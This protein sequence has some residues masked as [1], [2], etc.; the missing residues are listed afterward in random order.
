MICCPTTSATS[1]RATAS[2]SLTAEQ[3]GPPH[4]ESLCAPSP[5]RGDT[6]A[7]IRHRPVQIHARCRLDCSRTSKSGTE[8]EALAVILPRD[9]VL[10]AA[11]RI[12]LS[13]PTRW[14][15]FGR[16]SMTAT[17]RIHPMVASLL[18]AAPI[19]LEAELAHPPR[20]VG[21]YLEE[22]SWAEIDL[23]DADM[24]E[25][26]RPGANPVRQPAGQSESRGCQPCRCPALGGSVSMPGP[27]STR[28]I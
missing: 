22:A 9:L 14:T 1:S 23:A 26:P 17:G 19:R 18:H 16:L 2:P 24:Q 11:G 8:G 25:S 28:P 21:A 12:A 15:G 13:T 5:G 20:L 7:L 10:E 27:G 6:T 4:R 3:P